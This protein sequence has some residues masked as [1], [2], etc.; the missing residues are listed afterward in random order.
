MY[1][2]QV[3]SL[4]DGEK[5][6]IDRTPQSY[7]ASFWCKQYRTGS[8]AFTLLELLIVLAILLAIMALVYPTLDRGFRKTVFRETINQVQSLS[9]TARFRAQHDGRMVQ[10]LWQPEKHRI[11]L[12]QFDDAAEITVDD[13]EYMNGI[14]GSIPEFNAESN[15]G[16]Q[17]AFSV[18]GWDMVVLPDGYVLQIIDGSEADSDVIFGDLTSGI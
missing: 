16:A 2:D 6:M 10:I 14:D 9:A 4:G 5:I 13:S 15:I 8:R 11:I 18:T 3:L 12:S 7:C 17:T 1:L